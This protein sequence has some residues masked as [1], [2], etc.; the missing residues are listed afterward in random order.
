MN[1]GAQSSVLCLARQT[2]VYDVVGHCEIKVDVMG[3]SR[4]ANKPCMIW[5]H[6]GGLIFGSR[7]KSPRE[8]FL[9]ALLAKGFVVL[10]ID[11][12]LAPET[13]L[14]SI[15]DD[16]QSVWRWV[17][18]QRSTLGVDIS[19]I[20]VA[21]GSSGAYLSLISGYSLSPK[22]RALAS[23]WGFG[24]ITAPWEAEP[25]AFYRQMPLVSKEEAHR[26]VGNLPV[27]EPPGDVDRGYFYLYCRQQ[28]R[29]LIEVTGHDLREE[30][31]WFDPYCPIH[32]IVANY[33]PTV[34]VHGTLDTDV[35]H[36]ESNNL[37]LRFQQLGVKHEFLSLEGI[38]HGFSG[39]SA[40]EAESTELAV[41]AFLE[42]NL[43]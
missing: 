3:A 14:P 22:P 37:A 12:R 2:Y 27:S 4:D 29:W 32:N 39:A 34:L 31:G 26:S 15:V 38:G 9:R 13:K 7:I 20:A 21:G 36:E 40:E 8:P 35:P 10:S 33:P 17:L 42:A 18:A 16:V 30:P 24:D 19:R 23:F 43:A 11:H 28:G 41:A 6:G 5:I 25:S 1:T